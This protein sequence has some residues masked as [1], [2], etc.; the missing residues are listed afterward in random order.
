MDEF[1]G[2][3]KLGLKSVVILPIDYGEEVKDRL[4]NP[5]KWRTPKDE[6]VTEIA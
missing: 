3:E 6:F 5:K 1:L 2:L 4:V